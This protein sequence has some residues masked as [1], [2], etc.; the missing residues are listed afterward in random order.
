MAATSM[1]RGA[2]DGHPSPKSH[3]AAELLEDVAA[4]LGKLVEEED[5]VVGW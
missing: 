2:V 4:E 1:K 3:R 5:A